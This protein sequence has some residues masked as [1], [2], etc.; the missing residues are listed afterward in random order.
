MWTVVRVLLRA[1]MTFA[2][3]HQQK[4]ETTEGRP[5]QLL[6]EFLVKSGLT[7]SP[8]LVIKI[9]AEIQSELEFLQLEFHFL[10]SGVSPTL[11]LNHVQFPF[12]ILKK[13]LTSPLTVTRNLIPTEAT[14]MPLK[15]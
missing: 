2:S 8:T 6:Q 1:P 11:G 10:M 5:I 7:C 15:N 3:T 4:E 9:S 12:A 14:P 13:C